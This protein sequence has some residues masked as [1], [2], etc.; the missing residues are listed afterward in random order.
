[1]YGDVVLGV[2]KRPDEDHEPFETVIEKLKHERYHQ[3]V[4]D[5]KLTRDDLKELVTA[6]RRWSRSARQAVP[7]TRRGIS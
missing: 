1:M 6:S 7:R 3:D 4:E 5:T 2:Q